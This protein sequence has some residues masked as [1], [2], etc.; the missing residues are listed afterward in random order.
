MT[1][2][3]QGKPR[4]ASVGRTKLLILM[5]LYAAPLLA[6]WLWLGYVR[7]NEGAGVSVNG[8]LIV[9]AVALEAFTLN[10]AAGSDWQ[11]SQLQEKWSMV[12]FANAHC[13]A[14]CEKHLYHMRQVRLRT[15]RRMDRVQRV[16]VTPDYAGMG[17]KLADA[18]EGLHVVGGEDAQISSLRIQFDRAQQGMEECDNCIY[19]VDPFGNVM[20]RF[21]PELDPG[22]MYEDLMHLLK[23]SR[24]G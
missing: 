24:I 13:D 22:K 16:V 9:P 19:L 17:E 12:F 4:S 20:M 23:V 15:G 8:E 6:A 18:S 14:E 21:P 11:L 10:D 5:G 3:T 7:Q 2:D 1:E